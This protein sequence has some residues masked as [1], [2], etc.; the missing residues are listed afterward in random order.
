MMDKEKERG[1][2][3]KEERVRDA[4]LRKGPRSAVC[5]NQ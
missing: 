2:N 5:S 4:R 1:D 3:E